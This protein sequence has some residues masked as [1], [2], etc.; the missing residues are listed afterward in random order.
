MMAGVPN[1]S[2][3]SS[4]QRP[5]PRSPPIRT[6]ERPGDGRGRG[7]LRGQTAV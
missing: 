7:D 3:F 5:R 2:L 4:R 1:T 6:F